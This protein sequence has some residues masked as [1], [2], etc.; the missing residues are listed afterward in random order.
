MPKRSFY[1]FIVGLVLSSTLFLL[2]ACG[3]EAAPTVPPPTNTTVPDTATAAPTTKAATKTSPTPRATSTPRPTATAAPTATPKPSAAPGAATTPGAGAIPVD[4]N[5]VP[6]PVTSGKYGPQVEAVR[7]DSLQKLDDMN[8]LLGQLREQIINN[9]WTK[10]KDTWKKAHLTFLSALTLTPQVLINDLYLNMDALLDERPSYGFQVLEEEMFTKPKPTRDVALPVAARLVRD[11]RQ[12]RINM[13]K[14]ELD[15]LM[16]FRGM[17]NI[18]GGLAEFLGEE[19]EA[20]NAPSQTS[21][22]G[23]RTKLDALKA[24]YGIFS[25]AVIA[26]DPKIDKQVQ[27]EIK[28]VSQLLA[29]GSPDPHTVD[30]AGKQLRKAIDLAGDVLQVDPLLEGNALLTELGNIRIAVDGTLDALARDNFDLVSEQYGTFQVGWEGKVGRS[31]K[32]VDKTDFG[33]VDPLQK[34]INETLFFGTSPDK[35]KAKKQLIDLAKAVDQTI[36]TVRKI[37][38]TN[39][40]PAP[41]SDD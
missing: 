9:D 24:S 40:Q 11:G 39:P 12:A 2:A 5:G 26:R 8:S 30:L 25:P 19:E 36:A 28:T 15:G 31:V 41:K 21:V 4:A 17:V 14:A 13:E 38:V 34:S 16:V 29:S 1:L 22:I 6:L 3:E 7:R 23:T 10:A 32:E 33:I 18:C 35:E 20:P 27:D 37:P